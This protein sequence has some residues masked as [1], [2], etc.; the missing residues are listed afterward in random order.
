MVMIGIGTDVH[1]FDPEAPC[2]VAGLHWPDEPGL[3][4][5]SDGDVVAHACAD[6]LLN[7]AGLGD[8]GGLIGTD[9]P[10]WRDAAGLS[11]LQAVADHLRDHHVVAVNIGVQLIGNRPRVGGRRAEAQA[12]LSAA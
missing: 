7:A 2:W 12:A 6:A 11:I 8:L 1:A 5:H 4:G 3:A 10:E 9:R